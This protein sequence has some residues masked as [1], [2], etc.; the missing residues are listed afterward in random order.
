MTAW[1][2]VWT[3]KRD[4][5]CPIL[6]CDCMEHSE[7]IRSWHFWQVGVTRASTDISYEVLFQKCECGFRFLRMTWTKP[8][9]FFSKDREAMLCR[10]FNYDKLV[11]AFISIK[12][13]LDFNS[14]RVERGKFNNVPSGVFSMFAFGLIFEPISVSLW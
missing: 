2:V 13:G 9:V 4:G 3:V 6:V 7:H 8:K 5:C 12:F 1:S 14:A 11:W 10:Y